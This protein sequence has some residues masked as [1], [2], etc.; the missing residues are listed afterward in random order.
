MA[1]NRF[2]FGAR[3]G[4]S[5]LARAASDPR[6]V[7]KAELSQPAVARIDTPGLLTTEQALKALYDDEQRRKLEREQTTKA[8]SLVPAPN[9]SSKS[10]ASIAMAGRPA[11][12]ES[13]SAILS[14]TMASNVKPASAESPQKPPEKQVAQTLF[15]DEALARFRSVSH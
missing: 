9:S 8:Q 14:G 1:L 7:L 6:G 11:E 4:A 3:G 2:G 5:D 15:R 12:A 13:S 10:A